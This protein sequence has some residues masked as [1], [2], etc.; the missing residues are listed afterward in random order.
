MLQGWA[1]DNV[2]IKKT[3]PKEL[4]LLTNALEAVTQNDIERQNIEVD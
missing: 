4:A 3:M 2:E 1:N